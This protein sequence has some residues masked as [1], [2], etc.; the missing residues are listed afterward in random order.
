MSTSPFTAAASKYTALA[1]K[2]SDH[3]GG[4]AS[5]E[6][7]GDG[8]VVQALNEHIEDTA[9][10]LERLAEQAV[11]T[12]ETCDTQSSVDQILINAPSPSEVDEAKFKANAVRHMVQLGKLPPA[13]LKPAQDEFIDKNR[14]RDE[15]YNEH[16]RQ[17]SDTSLTP[18]PDDTTTGTSRR[19]RTL[20][21]PLNEPVDGSGYGDGGGGGDGSTLDD[22]FGDT[23]LS[24]DTEP[25]AA[26]A[27]A[28]PQMGG[29]PQ[30]APQGGGA[31]GSPPQMPQMPP[32]SPSAFKDKP[33]MPDGVGDL[34]SMISDTDIGTSTSG[35]ASATVDRGGSLH[36][37]TTR[38]DV[39]G[40]APS[41][42]GAGGVRPGEAQGGPAMR[43]GMGG[44]P[45][46]MGGI[47]GGNKTSKERPE[48]FAHDKKL[49]G[50]EAVENAVEGGLIGRNSSRAPT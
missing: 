48:I 30:G 22:T 21:Q 20:S 26:A 7:H 24:S 13:A 37:V 17:T 23:H 39:S 16:A 1:G 27:T 6:A 2:L 3:K 46:G 32:M 41:S 12:S 25:A 8:L 5:I 11:Q 18:P 38:A 36:G 9:R 4:V 42:V 40:A 34:G 35:D 10:G 19:S 31:H 45:M 29:Q 50:D 28:Q 33:K 49:L 47:G 43:G 14:E 15:A 44:M